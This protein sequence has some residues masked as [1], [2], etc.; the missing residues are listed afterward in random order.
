MARVISNGHLLHVKIYLELRD[1]PDPS[2]V[3]QRVWCHCFSLQSNNYRSKGMCFK[4]V[5]RNQHSL[6][7]SQGCSFICLFEQGL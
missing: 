6:G 4:P 5:A 7:S 1:K 3:T 2:S